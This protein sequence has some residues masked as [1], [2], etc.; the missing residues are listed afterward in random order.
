[1]MVKAY[2]LIYSKLSKI[3]EGSRTT[4]ADKQNKGDIVQGTEGRYID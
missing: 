4:Y 1:M 3:Y 2:E